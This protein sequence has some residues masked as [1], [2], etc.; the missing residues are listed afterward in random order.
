[1]IINGNSNANIEQVYFDNKLCIKK[2]SNDNRL[3][4]QIEKQKNE[5]SSLVKTPQIFSINYYEKYV[6]MDYIK[7]SSYI[8]QLNEN[9][10]SYISNLLLKY[11]L[12]EFSKSNYD[13]I[14]K[15][16]IINKF[17]NTLNNCNQYKLPDK[18]K[19]YFVSEYNNIKEIIIPIGKC[20]GDLTF[21]NILI[22]NKDVYLI[23]YLDSYIETPILDVIKLR[24]DVKFHW[25][26]LKATKQ[27]NYTI[28]DYIN[29]QIENTFNCDNP[30][31][32]LLE[33]LNYIRILPYCKDDKCY[34]FIIETIDYLVKN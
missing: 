5:T 24:Q 31:F 25:S 33:I 30:I 9:N 17:Y 2:S 12:E 6:I 8:E 7:N 10:L 22:L 14:D 16:I 13:I 15:S 21:S 32:K 20:H 23:D 4:K 1:M 34:K 27:Y 18:L 19:E 11:I 28:F 26:K 3:F 29:T